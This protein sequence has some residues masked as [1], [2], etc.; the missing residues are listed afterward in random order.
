MYI[1][2]TAENALTVE[3][4]AGALLVLSKLAERS[5]NHS[6]YDTDINNAMALVIG[7]LQEEISIS[8]VAGKQNSF[9]DAL[10]EKYSLLVR[11]WLAIVRVFEKKSNKCLQR[12]NRMFSSMVLALDEKL[13]K[14]LTDENII[15]HIG[16][17]EPI[18]ATL[19]ELSRD[20]IFIRNIRE[21]SD[22]L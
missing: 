2:K 14:I 22:I 10:I 11:K 3:H 7:Q 19:D 5:S 16:T 13:Y 8:E 9:Q 18:P 17:I 15:P 4:Y 21:P 12:D 1:T 20:G 6:W